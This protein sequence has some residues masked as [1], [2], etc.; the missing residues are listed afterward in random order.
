MNCRIYILLVQFCYTRVHNYKVL[1][2]LFKKSLQ[3]RIYHSLGHLLENSFEFK[4]CLLESVTRLFK[5]RRLLADLTR[6]VH[7]IFIN[8][9]AGKDHFLNCLDSIVKILRT[10]FFL[11]FIES[12]HLLY[13]NLHLIYLQIKKV[14]CSS[15]SNNPL[16]NS[17]ENPLFSSRKE[18]C[19]F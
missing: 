4:A 17:L 16:N 18:N 2:L 6:N 12:D 10:F 14:F 7:I 13:Y 1:V 15:V 19:C 3:R 8:F 5:I 9:Y 11:E